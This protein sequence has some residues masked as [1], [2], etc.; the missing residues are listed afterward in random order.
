MAKNRG[1]E[2]RQKISK[3][4]SKRA[5]L[6]W[7]EL[8]KSPGT[9]SCQ[10]SCQRAPSLKHSFLTILPSSAPW[11]Q[12][13]SNDSRLAHR[14]IET[15]DRMMRKGIEAKTYK[16]RSTNGPVFPLKNKPKAK[17]NTRKEARK[18]EN[19]TKGRFT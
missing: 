18:T 8:R 19:C 14:Q 7:T 10:S 9:S 13:P 15:G 11:N 2:I 17:L 1:Q 5:N 12:D 3:L 16:T 4:P 6:M